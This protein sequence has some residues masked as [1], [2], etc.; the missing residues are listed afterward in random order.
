MISSKRVSDIYNACL[1]DDVEV[2]GIIGFKHRFSASALAEHK[3]EIGQILAEL[4]DQFQASGGWSF[5]NMCNDKNGNQWTDLHAIME[6]LLMLGIMTDQAGYPLPRS[7]WPMLPGG[8]P[9]VVVK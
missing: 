8:M 5:L 2:E 7:F 4:P 6:A 1:G 3:A 9:Y